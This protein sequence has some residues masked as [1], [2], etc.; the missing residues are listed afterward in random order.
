MAT[1]DYGP[2]A[3]KLAWV[4]SPC[5]P[6]PDPTTPQILRRGDKVAGE[7]RSHPNTRANAHTGAGYRSRP[8]SPG[9]LRSSQR[10]ANRVAHPLATTI[11]HQ[12]E[13]RPHRLRQQAHRQHPPLVLLSNALQITCGRHC[14][15]C[16]SPVFIRYNASKPAPDACGRLVHLPVRRRLD[17]MSDM[18]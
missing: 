13:H 14:G 9:C 5:C 6:N 7:R 2:R 15:G 8:G 10:P 18:T 11:D 17:T 16:G 3:R 1:S 4:P 12:R